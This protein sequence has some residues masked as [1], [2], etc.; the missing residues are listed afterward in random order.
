LKYIKI[1]TN[2]YLSS[3]KLIVFLN[4]DWKEDDGFFYI[5]ED[6]YNPLWNMGILFKDDIIKYPE[7]SKY[8]L[9]N[10]SQHLS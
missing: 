8:I 3:L 10:F 6:K 9:F 2:N 1:I 4:K 5:N 7:N